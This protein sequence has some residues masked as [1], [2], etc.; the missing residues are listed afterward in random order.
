MKQ[1][2][3]IV[4]FYQSVWPVN[5]AL[6]L[7]PFLWGGISGFVAV[8]CTFGFVGSVGLKEI[9]RPEEFIFYYNNGLSKIKIWILSFMINAV[10][11]FLLAAICI[12]F[13]SI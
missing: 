11:G 2:R 9:V 7:L 3:N 12:L 8:F 5:M 10:V 6:S 4:A 1:F 13:K